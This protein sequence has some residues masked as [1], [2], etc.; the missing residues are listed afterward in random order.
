MHSAERQLAAVMAV[1]EIVSLETRH[2]RSLIPLQAASHFQLLLMHPRSHIGRQNSPVSRWNTASHTALPVIIM[3]VCE[4]VP[5]SPLW[6]S[7]V[8]THHFTHHLLILGC[9]VALVNTSHETAGLARD[10]ESINKLMTLRMEYIVKY[11][12]MRRSK[13]P[14]CRVSS[15]P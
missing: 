11:L 5:L 2:G 1:T 15:V 13:I 3:L 14:E 6:I 12:P 8:T 10:G 9:R 7:V 4:A